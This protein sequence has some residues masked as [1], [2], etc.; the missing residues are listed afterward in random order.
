MVGC[1]GKPGPDNFVQ[2]QKRVLRPD[3]RKCVN[4][5]MSVDVA[6]A[7][8]QPEFALGVLAGVTIGSSTD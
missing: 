2:K 4:V 8:A 7:T 3:W 6:E 5:T 1:H